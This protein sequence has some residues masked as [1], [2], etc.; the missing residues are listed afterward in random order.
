MEGGRAEDRHLCMS[1]KG[2]KMTRVLLAVPRWARLLVTVLAVLLSVPQ[3]AHAE[4]SLTLDATSST[5]RF[6]PNGDNQEDY[7][8]LDFCLSAAANV[9]VTVAQD[10]GAVVARPA[11]S[12][13]FPLSLIHI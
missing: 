11:T 3:T 5:A 7:V 9:T 12:R 10:T 13:S 6:S 4:T 8:V 1:H 2:R